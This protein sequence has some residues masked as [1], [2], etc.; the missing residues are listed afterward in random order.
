MCI[1]ASINRYHRMLMKRY[2]VRYRRQL[3]MRLYILKCISVRVQTHW[4]IVKK[5]Y[6]L[7][8]QMLHGR[9]LRNTRHPRKAEA[10]A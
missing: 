2:L 10:G 1:R 3:Q 5:G 6:C 7:Y 4:R 9:P 8:R